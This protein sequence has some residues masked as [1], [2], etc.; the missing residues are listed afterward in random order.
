M[1]DEE[2]RQEELIWRR[3]VWNK[4]EGEKQM[5]LALRDV[6]YETLTEESSPSI[7]YLQVYAV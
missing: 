4:G 3:K 5:E 7:L 1:L 6:A 2:Q